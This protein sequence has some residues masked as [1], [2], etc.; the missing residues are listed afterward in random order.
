MLMST[1]DAPRFAEFFAALHDCRPFPWQTRLAEQVFRDEAWPAI[2]DLP[3]GSGKTATLDVAVYY[4][5]SQACRPDRKAALRIVYVVDRRTIVD[6]AFERARAI[7]GRI[8]KASNGILREVREALG[9]LPSVGTCPL[10]VALLRG[11]IPRGDAWA[12][13]PDQPLI[14]VSTVDQVGSRLLFR[15]YGVSP[16]MRPIHAGLLGNDV[17][18]LLDEV[19]LSAPFCETLEQIG[20]R[21]R[22]WGSHALRTPFSVVQM[23]ATPGATGTDP[24]ALDEADWSH[25]QLRRRLESSKPTRL[26]SLPASKLVAELKKE[27]LDFCARE[28][29]TVLV[30]VNRVDTARRLASSL[31]ADSKD[32]FDV[33]LL[34]GRMRPLDREVAEAEIL[35]RVRA[36]RERK[37]DRRS[38]VVVSTQC[39]EAG[40]DFDFDS[41][42]TEC[43]SLDALRQRFGRLDR[44][45]TQGSAPAVILASTDNLK[46]DPIYGPALGQTWA[47]LNEQDP[48]DFGHTHLQL[49][50]E[51]ILTNLVPPRPH[52]PILLPAHLDSWVQTNPE[53][54]PDPD[55]AL[56]LH[57]PG[58]G[59]ADCQVVWRADL[60]ED[61]LR[62][63]E[64]AVMAEAVLALVGS[65]PPSSGEAVAIPHAAASRWLRGIP[66][67]TVADVEGTR[68]TEDQKP[69]QPPRP[70]LVWR[71]DDSLVVQGEDLDRTLRPGDTIVVP[72][73]YGGLLQG[74]WDPSNPTA[75][76]DLGDLAAFRLRGRLALRLHRDVL[77]SLTRDPQASPP[78][79][80]PEEETPVD[81]REI[82]AAWLH[83]AARRDWPADIVALVKALAKEGSRLVIDRVEV[84]GQ[85]PHRVVRSRRRLRFDGE[86]VNSED[87]SSSFT[88]VP[89]PLTHHLEGVAQRAGEFAARVGLD[90]ELTKDLRLAGFWHDIGKADPRFQCLL[91]GGSSF[92]ASVA[93]QP[94][95]KSQRISLRRDERMRAARRS[96]YPS[97]ARHELQSVAL[98]QGAGALLDQAHDADLVLH[99][100]ACHHGRCRPF[101]P[102]VPDPQ[103]LEVCFSL[104][105]TTLTS[106]SD[107][108]LARL[109]SGIPE[110]FWRLVR[111]YGWW[112]L[113]WIEALLR[114]GDHLQSEIEQKTEH[115]S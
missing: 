97:G 53:P 2:L 62:A 86:E 48:L 34:T 16:S 5:A 50:E 26:I 78:A 41:L 25:P 87:D 58:R 104:D 63:A 24:F 82:V 94:L 93:P 89:I 6:Q 33:R 22:S 32:H 51:S 80:P 15:G 29:S 84:P 4:L 99:L 90:Q 3:T 110:R 88:G 10:E 59:T 96:G 112:G 66:E 45:G 17:L 95:A 69:D 111:R 83:E 100:V 44:L 11:G 30:V 108:G 109:D 18:Y 14:A 43:A 115:P 103:P 92:R 57:G 60:S 13:R 85:E 102:W 105:G 65:V 19:H 35:P 52:A 54:W 39:I 79:F 74:T 49:P 68:E 106:T 31:Q 36:G 61:L 113:A 46:D 12:K 71:G 107:H 8:Q 64:D 114:L 67:G 56:W 81:E 77:Q 21:Y 7:A 40:A 9:H 47:W 20:G 38:L 23:S 42:V 27:A 1:L 73:T 70:C 101:A 72:A 55:V 98:L 75:V 37:P 91:H 76:R 28:G